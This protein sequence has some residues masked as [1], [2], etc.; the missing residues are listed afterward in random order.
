MY[1]EL[2]GNL[3][4]Q[5]THFS[6]HDETSLLLLKAADAIEELQQI[7]NHY[8]AEAKEWY[9][10]YMNLLPERKQTNADRIRTMSDE[11]LV[12]FLWWFAD[13]SGKTKDQWRDWLKQ[14][15]DKDGADNE[16]VHKRLQTRFKDAPTII[17]AD[18]DG[19]E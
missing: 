4:A 19:A 9:L 16:V 11:E 15:A 17:P 14:A 2:T 1:D 13:G 7:A 5:A 12:F 18:K 10:A 6:V 3:R 8:E